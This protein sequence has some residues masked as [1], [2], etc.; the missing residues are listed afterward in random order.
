M[1]EAG[2]TQKTKRPRGRPRPRENVERD[3]QIEQILQRQG[4][5]TRNA[6]ADQMELSHSLTYL[7]LVRLRNQRRVRRC[8][9]EGT[10]MD[11][12]WTTEVEAPCP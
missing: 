2:N 3:D 8:T 11:D 7:A 10:G 1:D 9:P 6:L 4:P 5:M 12:V